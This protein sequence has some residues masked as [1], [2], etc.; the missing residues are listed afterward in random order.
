MT[1]YYRVKKDGKTA[2]FTAKEW[3]AGRKRAN[4]M[5]IGKFKAPKRS[6]I[7]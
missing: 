2:V 1:Q 7:K 4:Q 3:Q 6:F 5:A